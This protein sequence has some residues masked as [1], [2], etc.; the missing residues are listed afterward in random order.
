MGM[1]MSKIKSVLDSF[2]DGIGLHIDCR[3]QTINIILREDAEV[4]ES[5]VI[6]KI[7]FN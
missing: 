6:N 7:K 2:C 4:E 3:E 1:I 5:E